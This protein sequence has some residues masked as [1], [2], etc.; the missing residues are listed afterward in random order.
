MS[1]LTGVERDRAYRN[2]LSAFAIAK[3]KLL[4][5]VESDLAGCDLCHDLDLI[6]ASVEQDEHASKDAFA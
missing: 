5:L 3:S 6:I 1:Y 2:S 4:E